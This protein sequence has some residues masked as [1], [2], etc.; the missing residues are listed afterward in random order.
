MSFDEYDTIYMRD[1]RYAKLFPMVQLF[2][3]DVHRLYVSG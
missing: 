1:M 2:V 3:Y